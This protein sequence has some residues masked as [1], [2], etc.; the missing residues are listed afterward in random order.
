MKNR[1]WKNDKPGQ[2]DGGMS[3]RGVYISFTI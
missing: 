3:R 1:F 2:S